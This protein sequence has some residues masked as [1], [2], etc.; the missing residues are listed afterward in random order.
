M[1]LHQCD[2]PLANELIVP[3]TSVHRQLATMG[4]KVAQLLLKRINGER[5]E[6]I[7]LAPQLKVRASFSMLR[8][9]E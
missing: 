2:I 1:K 8:R 4:R 6:S 3:L 9:A 7:I 5:A